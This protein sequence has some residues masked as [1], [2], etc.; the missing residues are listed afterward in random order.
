MMGLS[1]ST[2]LGPRESKA[3]DAFDPR[4]LL[5]PADVEKDIDER[6][7]GWQWTS[8]EQLAPDGETVIGGLIFVICSI[9]GSLLAQPPDDAPPTQQWMKRHEDW[10]IELARW[11]DEIDARG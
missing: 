5:S 1:V 9:C 7:G 10:H 6:T 4:V 8:Y 2:E 11:Q 3:R